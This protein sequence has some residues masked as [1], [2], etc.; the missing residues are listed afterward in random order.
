MRY[1]KTLA[2]VTTVA[3]LLGGTAVI[4]L[5]VLAQD[6]TTTTTTTTTATDE[7]IARHGGCGGEQLATA[8][9]ALGITEDELVDR[10]AA[11]DTV[12][13]VATAEGVP[14]SDVVAALVA[15]AEERVAAAVEDGRLTQD[16]A[17]TRLADVEQRITD[18]VNGD[19]PFGFGRD[20][21]GFG[22]FGLDAV[23][24]VLG[25]DSTALVER[26]RAGETLTDIA[27]A[28][29]VALDDVKTA[30]KTAMTARISDAVAD[31]RL[32]Q[33]QADEHLA[34]LADR[35]DAIV[36]GQAPLGG[37][38]HRGDHGRGDGLGLS[39]TTGTTDETSTD[40]GDA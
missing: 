29:G 15:D 18:A 30:I 40:T 17:D 22:G 3:A 10:L 25:L 12:A 38:P 21:H 27:T 2:G 11:G 39:D 26:L 7:G 37:H 23:A 20:R 4:A 9:E 28:E 33:E 24:E 34:D 1:R 8:A 36:S 32:T 16:E 13:D 5:P 31:G 35:I 6:E 14:V 19:A